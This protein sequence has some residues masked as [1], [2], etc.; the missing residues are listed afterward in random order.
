MRVLTEGGGVAP[1]SD[2]AGEGKVS[3]LASC[4]ALRLGATLGPTCERR[5]AVRGAVAMHRG[6]TG[7]SIAAAAFTSFTSLAS[8][9][10]KQ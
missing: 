10:C 8:G 3:A 4:A 9:G 6:K 5:R 7:E 2:G 1:S